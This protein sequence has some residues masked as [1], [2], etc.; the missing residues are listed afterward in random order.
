MT[1][2]NIFEQKDKFQRTTLAE[3]K[4]I[5]A[6]CLEVLSAEYSLDK[7]PKHQEERIQNDLSRFDTLKEYQQVFIHD[8]IE[9]KKDQNKSLLVTL[10]INSIVEV[11]HQHHIVR[12][13]LTEFE[14][15]GL[16]TLKKDYGRVYIRPETMADKFIELIKP[17]EVDFD[18]DKAFSR[19]YFVLTND[20]RKLRQQVTADFL[21]AINKHKGLEI[22]IDRNTLMVRLRQRVSLKAAQTISEFLT[23]INNGEN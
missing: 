8:G 14:F 13:N 16:V 18:I 21:S 4:Q 15:V 20:E 11:K 5:I 17:A 1:A 10:S 19:N 12:E 23:D 3:D 7:I 9:L 22:E 2:R 6:N